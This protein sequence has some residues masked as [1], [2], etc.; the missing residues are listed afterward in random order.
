MP[1]PTKKIEIPW[2]DIKGIKT[3]LE[4]G[5]SHSEIA[6]YFGVSQDSIS[7]RVRQHRE[8]E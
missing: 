6:D 7:R 3:Q 8:S 4:D 5:K 2:H 1:R